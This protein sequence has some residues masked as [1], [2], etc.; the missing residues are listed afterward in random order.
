MNDKDLPRWVVMVNDAMKKK[1]PTTE[2]GAVQNE[3]G[4][5]G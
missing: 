1:T 2:A 3:N 4:K 5:E